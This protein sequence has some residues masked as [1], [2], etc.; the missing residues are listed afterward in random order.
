MPFDYSD[1]SGGFNGLIPDNTV[2]ILQMDIIPGNVG[3]D[4]MLTR[5]STGSEMLSVKFTVVQ[6][7]YARN[8]VYANLVLDPSKERMM[9][10]N[11]GRLKAILDSA[12]N[13][14]PDDKSD[15][16]RRTRSVPYRAFDGIRF[17]G[18]IGIEDE[19][20]DKEGKTYRPKNV[21]VDAITNDR[22]EWTGLGPVAQ[23]QSRSTPQAPA[24]APAQPIERPKWAG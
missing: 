20:T 15:E 13:L 19:K 9:R 5:A 16:A 1:S 2:C 17:V 11:L 7:E 10:T 24:V 18:K 23:T 12:Y 14:R 22:N 8:V 21:L 4:G 6:G 3:E